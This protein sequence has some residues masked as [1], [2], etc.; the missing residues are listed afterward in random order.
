MSEF[1]EEFWSN[2]Y[3]QNQTGWDIGYASPALIEFVESLGNKDLSILIPGAGNAYEAEHLF[4][5]GYENV[6]VIDLSAEPLRNL[7]AR[8]PGFPDKQ[9]IQG[10]FFDHQGQYDVILEQTFFCALDP[11]LRSAYAK[12]MSELLKPDGAL[13][14]VLFNFPLTEDG[15]PF[16]GSED[17][18]RKTIGAFLDL[19]ILALCY[20]SIKP[21]QGSEYFFKA[22]LPS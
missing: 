20:N 14:G 12:K 10:D 22:V 16:G 4:N 5:A 6:V 15:P 3:R 11:K 1:N 8:V 13:A 17:E 2:R 21:R 9:L 7:K 19:K 18:Y